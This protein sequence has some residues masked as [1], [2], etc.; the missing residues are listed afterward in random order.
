MRRK[1]AW[2][3]GTSVHEDVLLSI[4]ARRRCLVDA[5]DLASLPTATD[6]KMPSA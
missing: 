3:G 1:G 5:L 6:A 2:V 4:D